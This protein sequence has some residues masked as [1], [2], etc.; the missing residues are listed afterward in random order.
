MAWTTLLSIGEAMAQHASVVSS[1]AEGAD[2]ERLGVEL[3]RQLE[4]VLSELR[5]KTD[6]SRTSLLQER[7]FDEARAALEEGFD[8]VLKGAAGF[9]TTALPPA[10]R[11]ATTLW[12]E[13][14]MAE[15]GSAL[16]AVHHEGGAELR[17]AGAARSGTASGAGGRRCAAS[18]RGCCAA[19]CATRR[20]VS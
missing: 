12:R 13:R 4:L 9:T 6:A 7:R 2:Y 8:A 15:I 11:S 3:N 14:G 17:R 19:R 10:R 16:V 20:R 1:A 5:T 18:T